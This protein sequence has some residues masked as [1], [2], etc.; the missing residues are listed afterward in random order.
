MDNDSAHISKEE[1][2][3]YV[4]DVRKAQSLAAWS[5]V[6]LIIP[7]LG[8]ILAG[9]SLSLTKSIPDVGN[10]GERTQR[11]R[12]NAHVSITLSVIITLI[13]VIILS[14]ACMNGHNQQTNQ[15]DQTTTQSSQSSNLATL[16]TCL[17]NVDSWFDTNGTT[18][19]LALDLLSNKEQQVSECQSE[20]PVTPSSIYQSQY[21]TC[22]SGVDKWWAGEAPTV[23]LANMMLPLK[24]QLVAECGTRYPVN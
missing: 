1:F 15:I 18:N 3:E 8:W 12:S 20:Y 13:W 9:I 5:Y 23:G 19:G 14:V 4:H 10:L 11:V 22:L 24:K 17:D 21:Q 16:G 2:R 7:L 6:G